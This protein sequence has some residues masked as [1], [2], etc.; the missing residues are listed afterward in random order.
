LLDAALGAT[1]E[2]WITTSYSACGKKQRVEVKVPDVRSRVA[3][4]ELLLRE[5]LGRPPQ[6]EEAAS[7]RLPRTAEAVEKLGWGD[8]KMIF[9]TQFASEIA[10]V[11]ADGDALL[12]ERVAALHEDQ[13]Q[14]LREALDEVKIAS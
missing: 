7:P 1:R 3:A 11:T 14:L 12:R 5:G 4:I 9:A 2:T 8:M 6:A 10:S 13:R